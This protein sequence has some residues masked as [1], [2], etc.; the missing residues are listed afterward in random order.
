MVT[1]LIGLATTGCAPQ[2]NPH[3]S[4][5]LSE[6]TN[7][8]GSGKDTDVDSNDTEAA[9][10]NVEC[11]EESELPQTYVD[12]LS[13]IQ[14]REVEENQTLLR[15][16]TQEMEAALGRAVELTEGR[17]RRARRPRQA[18]RRKDH[19]FF[20]GAAPGAQN[21][22]TPFPE[23]PGASRQEKVGE[24]VP[25]AVLPATNVLFSSETHREGRPNANTHSQPGA[26]SW[27]FG[28]A[29]RGPRAR[30]GSFG[31]IGFR[32]MR[33]GALP[34][35]RTAHGSDPTIRDP[36]VS[37]AVSAHPAGRAGGCSRLRIRGRD[38]G[39][40]TPCRTGRWSWSGRRRCGSTHRD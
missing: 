14:E 23:W 35:R 7:T 33:V 18:N 19:L 25:A 28:R 26:G 40:G 27:R 36:F 5:D 17:P 38:P 30:T 11:R 29:R 37:A 6:D 20:P 9:V 13:E 2:E 24:L 32:S 8:V 21:R 16:R 39:R 4:A 34:V 1:S 22:P 12:V 10:H 31:P 15:E 3:L